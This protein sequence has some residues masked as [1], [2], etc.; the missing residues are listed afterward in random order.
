M[1]RLVVIAFSM[2]ALFVFIIFDAGAATKPIKIVLLG[3]SYSAGNGADGD[4][5]GPTYCHRNTENWAEKYVRDLQARGY[6]VTFVNRACHGSVTDNIIN[7]KVELTFGN[8]DL[9]GNFSF[10]DPRIKNELLSNGICK[11]NYPD[12]ESYELTITSSTYNG[13]STNV[14]YKCERTLKSQISAVGEDTDLVLLTIGG[15]DLGFSDI[16]FQCLFPIDRNAR[17]CSK[18][19]NAADENMGTMTDSLRDIIVKLKGRMRSDAKVVLLGYPHIVLDNGYYLESRLTGFKYQAGTEIR[20]LAN[21]AEQGQKIASDSSGAGTFVYFLDKVKAHFTGHEPDPTVTNR[22]PDRWLHEFWGPMNDY[23]PYHPNSIGHQEYARLL[24][25]S[26]GETLTGINTTLGS[27]NSLDLVFVID[28]TGSMGD[29][30]AAVKTF[31]ADLVNNLVTKTKSYRFALVTYRDFPERTGTSTDY[32]SRVDLDFTNDQAMILSAINNIGLGNGGDL[33]ET[34]FSGLMSAIQLSWRPGVKKVIVQLGDAAPLNPEPNTG[35]TSLSVIS[36]SL[37]ID[38]AE[39]NVVNV[40]TTGTTAL[41]LEQIANDTGGGV[42]SAPSPTDVSTALTQVIDKALRKPY[43]WAG[44][45]YVTK[46]GKTIILNASGSF[47]PDGAIVS[48]E[49]DLNGDG[50]FEVITT[51]PTWP[52]T[53]MAAFDGIITLRV[54]DN[55][56]QSALATVRAYASKDGDEIPDAIDNCPDIANPG[57]ED[58]D[59]D[60]LGD[61]CDADSGRATKDDP[62]VIVGTSADTTP[63]PPPPTNPGGSGGGGGGGCFINTVLY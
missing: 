35:Y 47:D 54:T 43:A 49:W 40:S 58:S 9:V 39:V 41:E 16:I 61:A 25:Q 8:A 20:D 56:G 33:P 3:D 52:H 23:D 29:D 60:G 21:R 17:Q 45:P 13:F 62:D 50:I 46:I 31:A 34:V 42:Y 44:G 55:E 30:I 18:V 5:Y 22:N 14:G 48:Y 26:E 32:P 63:T 12:E 27:S 19:V 1:K 10:G 38:P 2:L 15:N 57:Q 53:F 36:A 11:N 4:P 7:D 24:I 6:N 37:A 28:T 59:G 51:S